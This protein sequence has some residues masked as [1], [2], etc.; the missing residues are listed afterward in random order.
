MTLALVGVG[1]AAFL[2]LARHGDAVDGAGVDEHLVDGLED[3]AVGT[4]VEVLRLELIHDILDAVRVDEHGAE[5]RLLRF[6]RMGHLVGQEGIGNRHE[7]A[8]FPDG[9]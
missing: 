1:K 5:H 2:Q 7:T 6:R 4:Q 8:S 9:V 3:L